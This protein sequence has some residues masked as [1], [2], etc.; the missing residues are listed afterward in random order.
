MC[1]IN[2][3]SNCPDL[4]CADMIL[5]ALNYNILYVMEINDEISKVIVLGA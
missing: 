2:T 4:F 5:E 1:T 3:E